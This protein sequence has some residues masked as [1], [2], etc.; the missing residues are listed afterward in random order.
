MSVI[1]VP[2]TPRGAGHLFRAVVAAWLLVL[3]LVVPAGAVEGPTKLFRPGGVRDVRRRRPRRSPSRVKYRNREGS[4]PAYVRVVIDGAAHEMTGDGGDDWK[5]G[6]G[7]HFAT[8]L[9]V[10][11]HDVSFVAADTRKFTD[12]VDGGTV[13][14]SVPTPTPDPTPTPTPTPKPDPTPAPTPTP[15][16]PAS[17]GDTAAR[18]LRSG[19]GS[20]GTGGTGGSGGSDPGVVGYIGGGDPG[21]GGTGG[22]GGSGGGNGGSGPAGSAT[23]GSTSGGSGDPTVETQTWG[24]GTGDPREYGDTTTG[25]TSGS[26]GGTIGDGSDAAAGLVAGAG[27]TGGSGG[28]GGPSG[29]P[30][31][32]S[33]SGPGGTTGGGGA[34]GGGSD[35][36]QLASA[37]GALGLQSGPTNDAAHADARQHDRRRRDGDGVRDLRQEAPRRGAAGPRRGARGERRPGLGDRG[38]VPPRA[39][40][41][42]PSTS[43]R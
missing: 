31:G 14:I 43:S 19:G 27:G 25:S 22:T 9:P 26:T 4:A 24:R 13:T 16:P 40:S 42:H 29:G 6:V 30:D 32:S 7:H 23:G 35:W 1:R 39:A 15:T 20:G 33:T 10:G 37:L 18:R 5:G 38:L 12:E 2:P 17:G 41:R 34:S 11:T 28:P 3:A 21:T 8:K 36:G